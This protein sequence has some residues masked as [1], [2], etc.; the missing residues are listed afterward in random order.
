LLAYW[1]IFVYFQFG[2]R[3]VRTEPAKGREEFSIFPL[4]CDGKKRTLKQRQ[5]MPKSEGDKMELRNIIAAGPINPNDAQGAIRGAIEI[6]TLLAA[7]SSRMGF[8]ADCSGC[9]ARI[10]SGLSCLTHGLHFG[11]SPESLIYAMRETITV[12]DTDL[13]RVA[14]RLQLVTC[15]SLGYHEQVSFLRRYFTKEATEEILRYCCVPEYKWSYL[16]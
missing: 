11:F 7:D 4:P 13:E 6:V 8:D 5:L 14:M 10:V 9:Q 15:I 3:A 2:A 12:G 16:P 1:S